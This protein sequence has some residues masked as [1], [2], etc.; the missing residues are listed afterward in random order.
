MSILVALYCVNGTLLVLHEIESA[1]EREW[2]ILRLPFGIGGFLLVHVP[3]VLSLFYGLFELA[4]DST[5]GV[6]MA[7]VFGAGGLVP[8]V[9]HEVV[10]RRPDR[11]RRVSSRLILYSNLVAGAALLVVSLSRL[12]T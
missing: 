2:E 5:T 10:A 6:V 4:L 7:A 3:L 1:Y 8:V 11:F 12:V 9:V